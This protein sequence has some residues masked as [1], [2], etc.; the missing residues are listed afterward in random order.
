MILT[1]L[2]KRHFVFHRGDIRD[3]RDAILRYNIFNQIIFE[4]IRICRVCI[5]SFQIQ[6]WRRDDSVWLIWIIPMKFE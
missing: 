3:I 2:D 4:I 5:A 1:M 6:T